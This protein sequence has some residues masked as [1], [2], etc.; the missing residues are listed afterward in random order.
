MGKKIAQAF[1]T[2]DGLAFSVERDA[3]LPQSQFDNSIILLIVRVM[4]SEF[5]L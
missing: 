4:N 2:M 5:S 3:E 1:F